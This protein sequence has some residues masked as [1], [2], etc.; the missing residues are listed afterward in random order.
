MDIEE[1]KSYFCSSY[2]NWVNARNKS[3][4]YSEI[5]RGKKEHL[6][7]HDEKEVPVEQLTTRAAAWKEYLK[8]RDLYLGMRL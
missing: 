2:R 1:A 6:T 7:E 5:R 3:L 4:Q 8:S